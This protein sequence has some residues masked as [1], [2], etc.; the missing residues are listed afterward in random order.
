MVDVDGVAITLAACDDELDAKR[1]QFL[2]ASM[3]GQ[4]SE[5]RALLRDH[6]SPLLMSRTTRGHTA[7]HLAA[8][9]AKRDV[10]LALIQA[11]IDQG[12]TSDVRRPEGSRAYQGKGSARSGEGGRSEGRGMRARGARGGAR[13]GGRAGY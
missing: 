6:G 8:F 4:A 12:A 2:M 11:G 5:V 3:N 1:L 9:G 10:V 7:L 13:E